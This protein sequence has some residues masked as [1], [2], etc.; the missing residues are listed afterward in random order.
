LAARRIRHRR[1][2]AG[3][4]TAARARKGVQDGENV[5]D[6]VDA[7]PTTGGE[8]RGCASRQT[9]IRKAIEGEQNVIYV[10]DGVATRRRGDVA[11]GAADALALVAH[12]VPVGITLTGIEEVRRKNSRAKGDLV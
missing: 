11:V 2:R 4:G 5:I 10:N 9:R 3:I 7:V 1:R 8:V 6:V 12:A